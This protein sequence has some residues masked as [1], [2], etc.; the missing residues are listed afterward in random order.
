MSV[1]A[2]RVVGWLSGRLHNPYEV[3]VPYST[4][5]RT[6][7]FVV[8]L[9]VA[10]NGP[11]RICT[12]YVIG[13]MTWREARAGVSHVYSPATPRMSSGSHRRGTDPSGIEIAYPTRVDTTHG[14]GA[15]T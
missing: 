14:T 10:A 4:T 1:M 9:M 11:A 13:A 7:A 6:G 5:E 2:C 12:A 15:L 3:V 8:H